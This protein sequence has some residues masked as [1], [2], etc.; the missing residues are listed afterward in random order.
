MN[1]N[2]FSEIIKVLGFGATLASIPLFASMENL[3]PPWPSSIA[4]VSAAVILV[5]VLLA[6]EFGA[7]ATR[8]SLRYLLLAASLLTLFGLFAYLYLYATLIVTLAD[9]DRLILGYTCN[10]DAQQIY[11]EQCPN[12][13]ATELAE[14]GYDPVRF[15]TPLSLTAAK[16]SL[17]AAWILFMAG[18][19]AAAGWAIACM[20]VNDAKEA[21]QER[22][23]GGSANEAPA[24]TGGESGVAG[25]GESPGDLA[26]PAV[27]P[28]SCG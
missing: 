21:A 14:G 8:R 23:R 9:G 3:Q 24:G 17:D 16:L 5:A 1:D 12:L 20:K 7:G 25:P 6:R 4:Y 2:F 22:A 13:T 15:F 28:Q 18:L 26:A 27:A 19:V 10:A 11:S